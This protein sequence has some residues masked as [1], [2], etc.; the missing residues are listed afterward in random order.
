[1]QK[2]AF[3]DSFSFLKCRVFGRYIVN[4]YAVSDGLNRSTTRNAA[5]I[6]TN[7]EGP[8][9]MDREPRWRQACIQHIQVN[10]KPKTGR[11][12]AEINHE[13]RVNSISEMS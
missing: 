1:M 2:L 13:S 9:P 10:I 11:I 5:N 8:T 3:A 12:L 6:N 4:S 7:D